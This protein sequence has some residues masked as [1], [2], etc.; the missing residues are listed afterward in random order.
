[1]HIACCV[2]ALSLFAP[3]V[4]AG[5]DPDNGQWGKS[6]STDLRVMTWN[7]DDG[8]CSS[9]AKHEADLDCWS[10]LAHIVAAFK[11]DVLFMQEAGDNDGYGTGGAV[12][13]VADLSAT[14]ELFLHG[15]MDIFTPDHPAVTAF[16]Q[17]YDSEFDLPCIYVSTVD[18]GYN[19]N[20]ILS[21]YPFCDLNGDGICCYSDIPQIT[22]D[23]YAPGGA[24]GV[25]GFQMAEIDLP[26]EVYCG[27]L[28]VGHGHLKA[29][30]YASDLAA[31][32]AAAQNV[33]YVLDY[34]YNGADCGIPDPHDRM[35]D[36]PP[37][38]T[39]LDPFT[40][41]VIGGDWNED[42]LYNER[43]GPADW[44]TQA[45]L[46]GETD[47]TDRDRS[48]MVYDEAVEHFSGLRRTYYYGS[49]K[50][51]YLAWQDSIVQLR[52]AFVFYSVSVPYLW[53]QPPEVQSY[54]TPSAASWDASKHRPVIADLILPTLPAR[55]C[56]PCAGQV[57]GDADADGVVNAFDIDPFV[58]ALTDV[59]A[60]DS[61][62]G[63]GAAAC[64]CDINSDG[65][66]NSFDIDPF[67]AVL[68]GG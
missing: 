11:P 64:R 58:L 16:V 55:D 21:R 61:E 67:V 20:V 1:M 23:E 32:L 45:A 8:I 31:R 66:V 54:A 24:G 59:A 30:G 43:R 13:S 10:A 50:Y 6:E 12:D 26:D 39:V 4:W 28:V 63:P 48:D 27:D 52:R 7:I 22:A 29:G 14:I 15:G 17:A 53:Q 47:G 35:A 41:L 38:A 25:R 57:L 37:A 2:W 51:D 9:A 46:L 42:E 5:W 56:G 68:V 36:S 62:Y 34:W 49:S 60:Y 19:R 44:M 40:P 65:Y 18:D 3:I 33:T